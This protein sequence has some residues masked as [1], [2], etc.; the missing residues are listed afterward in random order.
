M[1]QEPGE[2]Q[3]HEVDLK[4]YLARLPEADH[5]NLR[6]LT[7]SI[8]NVLRERNRRGSIK[9]VGGTIDKPLPRKDLDITFRLE[10]E[11]GDAKLDEHP[12]YLEYSKVR[13]QILREI[14]E[15]AAKRNQNLSIEEITEP[16]IDE[17]HQSLS[18]LK[19]DGSIKIKPKEGMIIEIIRKPEIASP[20]EKGPYVALKPA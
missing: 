7:E 15:E 18:I 8:S 12:N 14:V 3:E 1:D 2:R 6:S 4:D 16:I 9:A 19:N 5:K 20:V 13:F 10:E 17:E 11:E